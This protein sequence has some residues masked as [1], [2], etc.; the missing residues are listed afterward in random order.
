MDL[1]NATRMPTGYTLGVEASG[2]ELL[3]IVTKGTFVLPRRGRRA[4]WTSSSFRWS[5]LTCS[6][7]MPRP[8]RRP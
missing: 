1:I 6:A 3:C 4:L 5:P 2:R 8:V 7:A